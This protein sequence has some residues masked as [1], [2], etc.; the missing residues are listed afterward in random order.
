MKDVKIISIDNRGRIVLPLV[1]RKNLGI[2][3]DSQLMLVS[4]S[5]TKEIRITP[6]GITKEEK[7]I[8]FRITMRDEPGSLAKIASTFGDLGISLMYGESVIV[9]KSKTAIWTVISP[10]PQNITMDELREGL[11][12]DG[13]AINVDIVPFD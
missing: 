7:P 1:T 13:K 6:V 12:K 9:E 4:D 3:T 2:T 11:I 10:T 5:E 8:K